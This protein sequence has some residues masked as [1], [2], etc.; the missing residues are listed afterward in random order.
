MPPAPPSH[1]LR[2]PTAV[3]APHDWGSFAMSSPCCFLVPL[4]HVLH[5]LKITCTPSP[6]SCLGPLYWAQGPGE[7]RACRAGSKPRWNSARICGSPVVP[8]Y[9]PPTL[10]SQDARDGSMLLWRMTSGPEH[11]EQPHGHLVSLLHAHRHQGR[12]TETAAVP[13]ARNIA[14]PLQALLS[15]FVR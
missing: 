2:A 15:L 6:P 8:E 9:M 1:C 4:A 11:P 13:S 10:G 5:A 7:C 12:Q 14:Q 3:P